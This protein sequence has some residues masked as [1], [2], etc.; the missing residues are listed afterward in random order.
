MQLQIDQN[1]TPFHLNE[2]TIRG[3]AAVGGSSTVK[4][5][6]HD[7]VPC[8]HLHPLTVG[9]KG[10][11][12][13][14]AKPCCLHVA[15]ISWKGS[16]GELGVCV[17]GALLCLQYLLH[18]SFRYCASIIMGLYSF[19]IWNSKHSDSPSLTRVGTGRLSGLHHIQPWLG[20]GCGATWSKGI[21]DSI[22]QIKPLPHLWG[23]S[24]LRQQ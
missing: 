8:Q 16:E 15:V 7:N 11:A 3:V 23:Y 9:S 20:G 10:N 1:I 12:Q 22:P 19:Q 13:G 17:H 4:Y 14:L 24:D 18:L 21:Y 2:I 6:R 5:C